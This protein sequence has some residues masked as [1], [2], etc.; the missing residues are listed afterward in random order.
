MKPTFATNGV[1]VYSAPGSQRPVFGKMRPAL[2]SLVGEHKDVRFA[3]FV[4]A[5]NLIAPAL[6]A[7]HDQSQI[8]AERLQMPMACTPETD[9][10]VFANRG[11]TA[12]AESTLAKQEH[13]IWQLCSTLF[14]DIDVAGSQ[15]VTGVAEGLIES[16]APRVR[17]DVFSTFWAKLVAPDVLAGVQRA[18]TGEEKALLHLTGNNVVAACEALTAGNNFKLAMMVSQLSGT[19]EGGRRIMATQIQ[20]WRDRKDWSEM[21]DAVRAVFSILAGET[22]IVQGQAGPAEDKTSEFCISRRFKL[23]WQQSL[24]LRV[25]YGGQGTLADAIRAYTADLDSDRETVCPTTLWDTV[26]N[27]DDTDV[28]ADKE[29]TLM[30]LLRLYIDDADATELFDAMTV[31]GSA[32]NSRI[33]WQMGILFQAK[34]ICNLP[35]STIDDLTLSFA[36]ELESAQNIVIAAW[37]LL[38]LQNTETRAVAI[39]ALLERNAEH[40]PTPDADTDVVEDEVRTFLILTEDLRIPAHLIYAARAPLAKS[41]ADEARQ[42][43]YL[44]RAAQSQ[45]SSDYDVEAQ[46]IICATVGPDAVIS[47]DYKE[48][49]QLLPLFTS[50]PSRLVHGWASGAGVYNDFL[51]VVSLNGAQRRGREGESAVRALRKGIASL[52]DLTAGT[53]TLRQRVAVQEMSR[54]CDEMAREA[55]G[56]APAAR[57][58]DVEMDGSVGSA[59]IGVDGGLAGYRRAM[60]VVV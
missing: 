57:D 40:V 42:V 29:D 48:L 18:K 38:H 55:A 13:S 8:D 54:V 25:F 49:R 34:S 35:E 39:K 26:D 23:T 10:A 21:S 4:P 1:L 31:S 47:K 9:F 43:Y 22:C 56:Y 45:P 33:A 32:L 15:F 51:R 30:S 27:A 58:G 37:V 19:R 7:Q 3:K 36:A 59:M 20:G 12:A 52:E 53:V 11:R 17:L 50:K 6:E 14:D 2:R 16:L 46:E 28:F 24:G 41:L 60:G 44:L 5:K